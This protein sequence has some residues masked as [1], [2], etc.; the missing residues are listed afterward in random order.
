[1]KKILNEWKIFL[2]ENSRFEND[3]EVQ[4]HLANILLG[5]VD[6]PQLY[7]YTDGGEAYQNY[8]KIIK[9]SG[10]VKQKD[11]EIMALQQARKETE[12]RSPERKQIDKQLDRLG[13][14]IG[15]TIGGLTYYWYKAGGKDAAAFIVQQ[16]LDVFLAQLSTA[17]IEDFRENYSEYLGFAEGSLGVSFPAKLP[18]KTKFVGDVQVN[19]IWLVNDGRPLLM[20]IISSWANPEV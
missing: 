3:V 8:I 2:K 19:D 4:K 7:N 15:N 10:V 18:R 9:P 17:Q 6:Y 14:E 11:A 1:M 16:K 20:H 5:L 12:K 13:R